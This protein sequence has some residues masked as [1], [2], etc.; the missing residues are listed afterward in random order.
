VANQ[1]TGA[2]IEA[3][4]TGQNF[5]APLPLKEVNPGLNKTLPQSQAACL[6]RSED[7]GDQAA[8]TIVGEF[9]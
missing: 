4:N 9:E 7:P 3:F 1:L 5:I 2:C 6:R 8:F